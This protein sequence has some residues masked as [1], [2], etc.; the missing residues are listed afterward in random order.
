[1][2]DKK[3]ALTELESIKWRLIGKGV[4]SSYPEALRLIEILSQ[5][6]KELK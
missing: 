3:M 5:V 2:M 6:I 4:G 1:M